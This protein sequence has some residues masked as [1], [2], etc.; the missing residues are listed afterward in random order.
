MFVDGFSPRA[1]AEN[2]YVDG[3]PTLKGASWGATSVYRI[4]KN[5]A[6][7]GTYRRAEVAIRN[8]HSAII[9]AATFAAAQ[10]RLICRRPFRSP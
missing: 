9:S 3:V 8:N 6:Y 2:L 1:I 5:K 7:A 10:D 4:L